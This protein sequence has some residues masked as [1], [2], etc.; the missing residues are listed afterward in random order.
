[1]FDNIVKNGVSTDIMREGVRAHRD[2]EDFTVEKSN[3]M[4]KPM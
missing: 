4:N 2:T 1:M 3:L